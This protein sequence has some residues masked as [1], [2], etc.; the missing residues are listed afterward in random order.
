MRTSLLTLTNNFPNFMTKFLIVL[1]IM[2]LLLRLAAGSFPYV[3]SLGL[4]L[5]WNILWLKGTST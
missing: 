1:K 4:Q 2:F 3:Q 5:D